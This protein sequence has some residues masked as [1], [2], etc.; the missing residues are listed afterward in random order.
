MFGLFQNHGLVSKL[1]ISF[2]KHDGLVS[3]SWISFK[4]V[5]WFQNGSYLP[6][7]F[8]YSV[9]EV[10]SCWGLNR[11]WRGGSLTSPYSPGFQPPS[12]LNRS[13]GRPDPTR[14]WVSEISLNFCLSMISN[15][16]N[17]KNKWRKYEL[18]FK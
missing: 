3:K 1:R 11:G 17:I 14:T 12:Y 15:I 2:E 8:E 4:L 7:Q 10:V 5:D 6:S 9:L 18:T 16:G 13:H